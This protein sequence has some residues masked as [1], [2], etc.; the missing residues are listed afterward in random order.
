MTLFE[1]QFGINPQRD[2]LPYLDGEYAIGILE[3]SEG[4]IAEQLGVPLN[5]LLLVESSDQAALLDAAE[6]IA[7]GLKDTG[8][9]DVLQTESNGIQVFELRDPFY[10]GTAF[11]YAVKDNILFISLDTGTIEDVYSDRISL[12]Q[13]ARYKDGWEAFPK[14][15]RPIMYIDVEGIYRFVTEEL[16]FLS[17]TELEDAVVFKPIKTIEIA[18]RIIDENLL[19][20]TMIIFIEAEVTQ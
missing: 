10:E 8:Q 17:P 5:L 19:H 2:L 1:E 4:M 20:S 7:S 16:G 18:A 14:D 3:S 12:D 11:V 6:K 15:M 13:Y 9:Y